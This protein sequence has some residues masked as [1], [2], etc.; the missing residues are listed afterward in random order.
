[1]QDNWNN[2]NWPLQKDTV[3]W[4]RKGCWFW[5]DLGVNKKKNIQNSQTIHTIF[6]IKE[7][8]GMHQHITLRFI[9]S[10]IC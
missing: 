8:P 1:M 5:E 7:M 9:H 4:K 3:R 10:F 6:K 2:T